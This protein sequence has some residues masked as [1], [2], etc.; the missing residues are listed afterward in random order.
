MK[1][2]IDKFMG[3]SLMLYDKI[4]YDAL[5]FAAFTRSFSILNRALELGLSELVLSELTSF[6]GVCVCVCVCQC[7]I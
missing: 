2:N 3:F 5:T 7:C 4:R 1:F 6:L